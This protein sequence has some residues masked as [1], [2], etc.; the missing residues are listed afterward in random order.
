M[1]LLIVALVF[2]MTATGSAAK[3]FCVGQ[4]LSLLNNTRKV[5]TWKIN[6]CVGQPLS[7]LNNTRKVATWKIRSNGDTI[8]LKLR[9]FLGDTQI[10]VSDIGT[11]KL[12]QQRSWNRRLS[13]WSVSG[14]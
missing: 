10:T 6:F 14:W 1:D 5:A 12:F 4:P 7:L 3:N 9:T 2:C 8:S 11:E 13:G